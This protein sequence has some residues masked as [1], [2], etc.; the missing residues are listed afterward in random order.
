ML[1]L[2]VGPIVIT[3]VE[4]A[5]LKGRKT[6]LIYA[7]GV[8]LSDAAYIYL[9]HI[10]LS[11][12]LTQPK[13]KMVLGLAGGVLL[14]GLGAY[15]FFVKTVSTRSVEIKFSDNR[16]AFF[17]GVLINTLSP[18]VI[19]MWIGVYAY[20]Q[21]QQATGS[22]KLGYFMGFMGMIATL[23]IVRIWLANKVKRFITGE[24]IQLVRRLAGLGLMIFGVVMLYR[25]F[26]LNA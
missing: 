17:K 6:A 3:M 16:N 7:W 13:V 9:T 8:W 15:N 10:G 2:M 14:L 20:L 23:D 25:I 1:G 21:S 26:I 4:T 11:V 18:F 22:Q 19:V 5:V 24:R 12:F